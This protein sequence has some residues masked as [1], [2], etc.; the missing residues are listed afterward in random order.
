MKK[1]GLNEPT[2]IEEYENMLKAF[3]DNA[4]K[5]LGKDAKNDSDDLEF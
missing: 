5:L 2:N 4:S 1:L 3:K